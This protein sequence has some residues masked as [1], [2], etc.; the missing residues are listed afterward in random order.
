MNHHIG[1]LWAE[2]HILRPMCNLSLSQLLPLKRIF[3]PPQQYNS[4]VLQQCAW[5]WRFR[6]CWSPGFAASRNFPRTSAHWLGQDRWSA[7]VVNGC[8]D[9]ECWTFNVKANNISP[10][11]SAL[12]CA[13][14]RKYGCVVGLL[15]RESHLKED[16]YLSMSLLHNMLSSSAANDL[17]PAATHLL[18]ACRKNKVQLREKPVKQSDA[19][20]IFESV[21]LAKGINLAME[22]YRSPIRLR[23]CVIKSKMQT[24]VC[25]L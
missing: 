6:A 25:K 2:D 20:D 19:M 13:L 7:A 17:H 22:W 4:L 24:K 15:Q 23:D 12:K 3:Q 9:C 21:S 5:N 10:Q 11:T 1:F 18:R 14:T 16:F 8:T